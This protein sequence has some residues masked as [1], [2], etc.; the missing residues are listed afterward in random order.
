MAVSPSH[1]HINRKFKGK[2]RGDKPKLDL[3]AIYPDFWPKTWGNPPLLGFTHA[4]NDFQALRKAEYNGTYRSN[5][6]FGAKAV[7][8][9]NRKVRLRRKDLY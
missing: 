2:F 4:E 5:L 8:V 3:Y 6:S 1:T 7:K 9:D